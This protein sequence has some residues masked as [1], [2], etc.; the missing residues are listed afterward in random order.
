MKTSIERIDADEEL[1]SRGVPTLQVT[2]RLAD[3]TSA[4][5]SVPSGAST[6]RREARELRDGDP[7]RYGGRGVL[8]AAAHVRSILSTALRGFDVLDQ[9]RIDN[10]MIALD[11]T[12]NKARLGANAIVGVSMAVARAGAVASNVPLYRH[13]GGA[14]ACRLPMP[15][16]NVINGGAHAQNGL[17]FQEFM[18]VP[19]GAPSYSEALRYGVETYTALRKR[20]A[21]DDCGT[22]VGDEGGFAPDLRNNEQACMAIVDAIRAAGF[23]PGDQVAMA[24]DPAASGF[25]SGGLYEIASLMRGHLTSADLGKVYEQWIERYP[26]VSI[27]DGFDEDDWS[28]FKAQTAALGH[29]IQIVGDDLYVTDPASIRRGVEMGATNAVLIK[30]NQIGT[31]SETIAAIEECRRAGWRYIVSHRSGETDDSF[32]AD[33]AVA[34]GGG[35]IKAGAPCRGERIAKYNRL[36]AIERELGEAAIFADP[37]AS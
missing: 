35:Q 9:A 4:S 29:R 28:A 2:V 36:L 21:R 26:I 8:S 34:M 13:L 12:P 24:L 33:F 37:F 14:M 32:I 30:L 23:V 1:D 19:R 17:E 20:L 18:I 7:A 15:M 31:I 27:E 3:G 25:H 11:G 16:M 10:A 5:A 22:G 6:G